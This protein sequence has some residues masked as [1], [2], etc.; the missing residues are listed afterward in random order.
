MKGTNKNLLP[1]III[2][3]RMI[4]TAL[5]YAYSNRYEVNNQSN[6]VIDKWKHKF[7]VI[8]RKQ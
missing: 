3:A 6:L 5:I 7:S 4:I 2:A 1:A 8:T